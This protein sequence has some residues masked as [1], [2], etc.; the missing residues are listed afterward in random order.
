MRSHFG[1]VNNAHDR[2]EQSRLPGGILTAPLTDRLGA[3]ATQV[4]CCAKTSVLW[5]G[6]LW[7]YNSIAPN[8]CRLDVSATYALTLSALHNK[9]T[10]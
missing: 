7:P 9:N 10:W 6:S 3:A 1:T 5:A 8:R 4:T 2:T